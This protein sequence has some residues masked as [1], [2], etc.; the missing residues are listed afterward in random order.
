M[1]PRWLFRFEAVR[2]KFFPGSNGTSA[3]ALRWSSTPTLGFPREPFQ[4][5]RRAREALQNSPVPPKPAI[6]TLPAWGSLG[7]IETAVRR[8]AI[9]LERELTSVGYGRRDAQW[10]IEAALQSGRHLHCS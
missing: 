4:G 6:E 1:R 5:D 3:I 2:D 9:E 7:E 10:T 8:L